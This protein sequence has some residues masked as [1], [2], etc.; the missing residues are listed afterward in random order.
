MTVV[1][2]DEAIDDLERIEAWLSTLEHANP[3]KARARI[4]HAADLLERLGDIGRPGPRAG[5]RELSVRKAPYVIIYRSTG[6]LIEILAVY[7]TAQQ[8]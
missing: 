7:H 3:A 4:G 2:R 8:R 5:T 1:W 6:D